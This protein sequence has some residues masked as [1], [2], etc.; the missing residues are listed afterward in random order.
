[1]N[2]VI[3]ALTRA[4]KCCWIVLEQKSSNFA[5]SNQLI[6]IEGI[7]ISMMLLVVDKG[8]RSDLSYSLENYDPFSTSLP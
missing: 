4:D 6:I 5:L 3:P 7:L 1:M 8:L 2:K